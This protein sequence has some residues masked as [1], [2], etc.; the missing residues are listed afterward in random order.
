MRPSPTAPSLT[1]VVVTLF[2]LWT[3]DWSPLAPMVARA[4]DPVAVVTTIPVLKDLVQQVGQSHVR[5]VSLLT[6]LENEHSYSPKPSD[7]IAVRKARLFVEIGAGLEVWVGGLIRSAG[8]RELAVVTVSQGIELIDADRV[9]G[10]GGSPDL[11][12]G[13]DAGNP[14]IWLDP[15]NAALIVRRI[16]E[17]LSRV[18]PSHAGDY[19]RS[20]SSYLGELQRTTA[21]LVERLRPFAD[22]RIVTHHPAWPYFARRFHLQIVGEILRQS[23]AE[24]SP[25][26]LRTLIEQMRRDGVK[27]IVSEPQLNQKLPRVVA[28][29]SGARLIVLTALPGGVPGTETYLDMLR[30]NVLQ[31][32]QAFERA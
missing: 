18:D 5:V 10:Q 30:Y 13:H 22:R 8:N 26:H 2:W 19:A 24:P 32:V 14:H 25:R 17:S 27:V 15:D 11:A 9:P 12:H 6:G 1:L 16:T 3:L 20:A 4:E 29:E 31:L 7:L 21:E 23:G 28:E